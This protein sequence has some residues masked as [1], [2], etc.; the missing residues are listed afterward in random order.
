MKKKMQKS[1]YLIAIMGLILSA[2]IIFLTLQLFIYKAELVS[3]EKTVQGQQT[4]EKILTFTKLFVDKIFRKDP[5]VSFED[6][7]ELENAVRVLNNQEIF[8]Q[9]Q[10]FT[11]S[12]GEE[13]AQT[14]AVNLF[15][16]L[17][18]NITY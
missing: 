18:K 10:K 12:T 6:R 14:Q 5:Q 4:N 1:N 8:D 15:N 16:L 11:N 13:D 17:L 7:L 9:W 2:G 3:A